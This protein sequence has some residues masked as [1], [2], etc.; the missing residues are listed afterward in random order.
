MLVGRSVDCCVQHPDAVADSAAIHL[1]VG[2]KHDDVVLSVVMVSLA[3]SQTPSTSIIGGGLFPGPYFVAHHSIK[4]GESPNYQ[5][6][7]EVHIS[8]SNGSVP[9]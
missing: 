1:R 9:Y 3:L 7:L 8:I 6:P 4:S 2:H 5:N